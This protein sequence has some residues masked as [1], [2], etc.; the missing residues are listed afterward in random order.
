MLNSNCDRNDI[1]WYPEFVPQ[2]TGGVVPPEPVTVNV[3]VKQLVAKLALMPV[4]V[5]TEPAAL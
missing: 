3:S 5:K 1:L 4:S 2:M